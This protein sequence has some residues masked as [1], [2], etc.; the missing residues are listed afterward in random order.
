M[1]KSA[2]I[3]FLT[4]DFPYAAEARTFGMALQG[5]MAVRNGRNRD[6]KLAWFH[7]F[8]LSTLTAFAGGT[9]CNL[10]MGKPTSMLSNDLNLM[11]CIAAFLIVNCTPWDIGYKLGNFYPFVMIITM[12]A[13][14]FR[15]NGL[16]GF[17]RA[18]FEA[19][20]E[21]T[22]D[23]YPIPVVGPILF[24]TLLGN[25]GGFFSKGFDAYLKNGMPWPFQVG[26]FGS[27]FYH[28]LIHDSTGFIGVSLRQI[29]DLVPG[30]KMGLDDKTFAVVVVSSFLQI[31][32]LLQLPFALGASFSPFYSVYS[33][34][35]PLVPNIYGNTTV[36][37]ELSTKK[38]KN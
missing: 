10:W 7:A 17:T 8:M 36:E 29:L 24:G 19:F 26:L 11:C 35:E 1:I 23:Y 37:I 30:I 32:G 34:V 13:Q 22:S 38:K 31:T 33:K 2:L 18:G 27:S 21:S 15:V 12:F 28:F 9:F 5:S 6:K 20:K 4:N 14:L 25:M 3:A 16:I